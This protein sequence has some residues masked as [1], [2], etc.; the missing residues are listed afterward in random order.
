MR[1]AIQVQR[2]EGMRGEILKYFIDKMLKIYETEKKDEFQDE[3]DLGQHKD[4][5]IGFG[6]K[7]DHI[8]LA[9]KPATFRRKMA[10]D[11]NYHSWEY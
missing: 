5:G 7:L 11:P 3:D 4:M 1:D 2:L 10:R 6:Q 9:C 8:E